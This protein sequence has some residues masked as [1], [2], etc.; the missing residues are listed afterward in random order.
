MHIS[1]ESIIHPLPT[2]EVIERRERKWR[3]KLP[4]GYK[5]FLLDFNGGIPEQKTFEYNLREYVVTRFLCILDDYRENRYGWYDVS[6][7]E[8]QLSE[9]LTANLDLIGVEMLPIAEL[10]SGDYLCMD[11]RDSKEFPCICVWN[12]EE[13]VEFDPVTYKVAESFSEFLKMLK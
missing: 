11:F 8:S 7:V 12:H 10:F 2:L 1:K 9:R 5:N 6:V 3:Q 13:S 4:E